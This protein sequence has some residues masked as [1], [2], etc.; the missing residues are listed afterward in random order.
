MTAPTCMCDVAFSWCRND[1]SI[2]VRRSMWCWLMSSPSR[3]A[4]SAGR[5]VLGSLVPVPRARV[6]EVILRRIAGVHGE[7]GPLD[8]L[9][10]VHE[11]AV[12]AIEGEVLAPVGPVVGLAR[13]PEAVRA[14]VGAVADE[15][16]ARPARVHREGDLLVV[17]G[18]R[19][20]AGVVPGARGRMSPPRRRQER[21]EVLAIEAVDRVD[22]AL[23]A[24]LVAVHPGVADPLVA[25]ALLDEADQAGHAADHEVVEHQPLVLHLLAQAARLGGVPAVERLDRAVHRGPRHL[26]ELVVVEP[27]VVHDAPFWRARR[28]AARRRR[29]R[30]R[31]AWPGG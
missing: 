3:S 1:A 29:P 17:L 26:A 2:A 10:L 11:R 16:L 25:Q 21:H 30:G 5:D 7:A 4:P 9:D 8:G 28:P 13:A 14:L 27:A 15:A 6:L 20:G 19:E 24:T 31:P 18:D 22:V 12:G 23:P